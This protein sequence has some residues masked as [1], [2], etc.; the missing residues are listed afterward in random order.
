MVYTLGSVTAAGSAPYYTNLA[1]FNTTAPYNASAHHHHHH[2]PHNVT[3]TIV[4]ATVPYVVTT[5]YNEPGDFTEKYALEHPRLSSRSSFRGEVQQTATPMS[6]TQVN[7]SGLK[8]AMLSGLAV[9]ILLLLALLVVFLLFYFQKLRRERRSRGDPE[10]PPDKPGFELTILQKQYLSCGPSVGAVEPVV[11]QPP[12]PTTT[13]ASAATKASRPTQET[14]PATT[15]PSTQVACSIPL[16]PSPPLSPSPPKVSPVKPRQ[17]TKTLAEGFG[18]PLSRPRV[19][20]VEP[21]RKNKPLAWE[22]DRDLTRENSQTE[23]EDL[24][25]PELQFAS[26]PSHPVPSPVLSTTS[27]GFTRIVAKIWGPEGPSEEGKRFYKTV[28]Q[29]KK[30]A[31]ELQAE[32]AQSTQ[33]GAETELDFHSV[34]ELGKPLEGETR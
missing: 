5:G 26:V 30:K 23:D 24:D 14:P 25:L 19:S 28:R 32:A 29:S 20:P 33:K 18:R 21:R 7:V 4:T 31:K 13:K 9:S 22:L 17:K 10:V 15:R 3:T 34:S 27:S 2:H 16:P 8:T 12:A 6:S 1:L 11:G